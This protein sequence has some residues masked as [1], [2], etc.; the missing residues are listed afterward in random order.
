MTLKG[1]VEDIEVITYSPDGKFI[2]SGGWDR[3]IRIWDAK[4]GAEVKNFRAHD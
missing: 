4:T 3:T 1:H 2:A